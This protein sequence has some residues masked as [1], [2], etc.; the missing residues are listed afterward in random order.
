MEC[1]EQELGGRRLMEEISGGD[2][3]HELLLFFFVGGGAKDQ[4]FIVK[5]LHMKKLCLCTQ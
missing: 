2:I 3:K 4:L 1:E 5:N